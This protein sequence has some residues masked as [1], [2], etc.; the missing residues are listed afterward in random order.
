MSVDSRILVLLSLSSIFSA[1][2]FHLA[3]L[4]SFG[5]NSVNKQNTHRSRIHNL[6]H[7]PLRMRGGDGNPLT[8]Q[9]SAID[10][11]YWPV[12]CGW[13]VAIMFEECGLPYKVHPIDILKG[14]QFDPEYLK[15][16]PNNKVCAK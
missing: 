16:N 7:A 10:F 14:D 3:P 8:A 6:A 15:L 11:Y 5:T 13:K 9:K 12:P 1:L 2:G 4:P